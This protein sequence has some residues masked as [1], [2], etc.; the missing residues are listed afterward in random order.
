METE[1]PDIPLLPAEFVWYVPFESLEENRVRMGIRME[2]REGRI[3]VEAVVPGSPAA[4]AGMEKGDELVA[5]DG[6]PVRESIDVSYRVGEKREG[7]KA[8]VTVRRA[9]EE[10]T[11]EVTFFR[12]P[13][14]HN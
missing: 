3:F 6:D 2:E 12:I 10:K 7:D 9:G 4:K 13:K 14:Q 11:L 8:S 1:V 5:F